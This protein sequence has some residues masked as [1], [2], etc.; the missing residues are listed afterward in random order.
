MLVQARSTALNESERRIALENGINIDLPRAD[1]TSSFLRWK[2]IVEWPV[3][4]I[5]TGLALPI[6]GILWLLVRATSPGPGFYRQSRTGLDGH[7]FVMFKLRTMRCDAEAVSGPVWSTH[8]DPRVTP[9]GRLL[10]TFHLDEL[11]QLFNV[12]RL[13]MSLVGPRPERPEFVEVLAQRLD[14]YRDRLLV[15]PGITGLAQLNLPP[16]SDLHSVARKLVLDLEYVVRADP[17]LELRLLACTAT[18]MVKVPTVRL[19]GLQRQVTLLHE[20]MHQ[21]KSVTLVSA[22]PIV[23]LSYDL[24][25]AP[26]NGNGHIRT[27]S[28]FCTAYQTAVYGKPR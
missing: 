15:R 8:N 4:L 21:Q 2:I 22:A 20:V 1:Q 27:Q 6:I 16:D 19:M 13:E 24:D 18:R 23:T 12:L 7:P 3:A 5:L 11:P 10:R 28:D 26:N 9:L 25:H 14:R 17:W